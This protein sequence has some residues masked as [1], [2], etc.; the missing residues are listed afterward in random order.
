MIAEA[1]EKKEAIEITLSPGISQQRT[2]KEDPFD[3]PAS[4]IRKYKDK[5]GQLA[6][7]KNFIRRTDRKLQKDFSGKNGAH[8]KQINIEAIMGYTYLECILPPYNMSWLAKLYD[9]SPAHHAAVN[10][11]V[12]SVFGLGYDWIESPKTELTRSAIRTDGGFNKLETT[13]AKEKFN[14]QT[15][16]ETTNQEDC[17]EETMQ[18]IGKDYETTGNGYMEIGRDNKGNIAYIG[19]VP[20]T[21]IRVRK[22][23]D[24][25]VQIFSN[26]IVFFRNFGDKAPN[27]VTDDT[28]PNE[29]IHFK[30]YSPVHMY[31][32]V[33][34]VISAK[35][36][37]AGN[38]FAN[39]YNLD[40]FE[41]KA[42]P[43]H[44]IISK[45]VDLTSNSK[46]KLVQ[47][48][49]AGL[50]GQHHRSIYIPLPAGDQ[51][52]LEFK[53][54]EEGA[55]DF[56][57]GNYRKA[58]NEEIFMAH[59]VPPTRAGVFDA[60]VALA[61][62]QEADKVF[63]ESYSSPEQAIFEKK[64]KKVF[65]EITDMFIFTL[66]ELSLTDANTQSQMD[67]R[68]IRNQ[69]KVPDEVR[70][71]RSMGKRPDGKGNEPFSPSAQKAADLKATATKTRKRDAN[72]SANRSD[73]INNA[74]G[75]SPKGTG[76]R[77]P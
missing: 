7:N 39:R 73:D 47:F 3:V 60:N 13:L 48:F 66:N 61:A 26:N 11:K 24:G 34:D 72:R 17:F 55:A 30:K 10:A 4:E 75:R 53:S 67:E 19:H 9:I 46:N 52:S 69:I 22:D 50:R 70:A 2:D 49:E 20:S 43:R 74:T 29:L 31:Y 44:V 77:T 57:F 37:L 54:I 5:N 12:E 51:V 56:S 36:P 62:A 35:N 58:N 32:G 6:L 1:E 8:S 18:K 33:P 76:R 27:V 14:I 28:N 64:V 41:N 45:G 68:D 63:K 59:R 16:L 25:F 71:T 40:F 65:S 21:Y 23:R 15:W 42:V 38:E